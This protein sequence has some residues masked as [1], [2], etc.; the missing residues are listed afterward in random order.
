M[1]Q[2]LISFSQYEYWAN[3]RLLSVVMA[4]TEEQQQQP[5]SSSFPS[6]YKT[7]LHVWDANTIW[8][9]RLHKAEE[10]IIPSL[11]FHPTMQEVEKGLL[12][13]NQ[14]WIDWLRDTTEEEL[15]SVLHYKSMKG[16][17]YAQPVKEIVLHISNHGTY[18]R[19]QV[20][21]MLRQVGV[22]QIPQCDYILYARS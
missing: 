18:H 4:L 15:E 20:V 3:Q 2:L 13:D 7:F 16:D 21:T 17:P 1:K 22:E 11:S 9:Q 14:K 10:I 5:I 6:I 12:Q 19:G 8:W